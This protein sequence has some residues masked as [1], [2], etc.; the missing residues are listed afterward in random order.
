MYQQN[1]E[2]SFTHQN[3]NENINLYKE[4]NSLQN[5]QSGHI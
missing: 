1:Y 5:S 2:N 3:T 4:L